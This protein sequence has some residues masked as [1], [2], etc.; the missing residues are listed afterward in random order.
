MNAM[1][2][3]GSRA[4]LGIGGKQLPTAA[5]GSFPYRHRTCAEA[6]RTAPV[7]RPSYAEPLSGF[8]APESQNEKFVARYSQ[9]GLERR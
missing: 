1:D 7:A 9:F 5:K 4:N 8:V 2:P 6:F 3:L